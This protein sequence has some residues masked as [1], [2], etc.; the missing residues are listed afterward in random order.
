[1]TAGTFIKLYLITIPIFFAIDLIWLG[2]VAKGFYRKHLGHL[3]RADVGWGAAMLFYLIFIAGILIFA[4]LPAIERQSFRW[5]VLMGGLFGFI[6]YATYD[7]TNLATLK[8]FPPVVAAVDMLWG[9]VLSASV[10]GAAFKVA[11]W[12]GGPA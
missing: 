12:L 10:A 2:I 9:F 11:Q 1:M 4:V 5:A 8:G 7:L 3:L 6:A